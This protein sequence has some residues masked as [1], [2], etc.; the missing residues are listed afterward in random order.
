[1]ALDHDHFMGVALELSRQA[2]AEGNRPLGSLIVD[3][4]GEMWP[5][6]EYGLGIASSPLT[7]GGRYWGHGG[8]IHGYETRGGVTEN[9]RAFSVAVTALPG[10]FQ[11]TPE[12]A[13]KAHEAVLA[14]VDSALCGK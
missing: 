6:A 4:K 14:T 11:D 9:G 10:T 3:T 12:D 5:G 8:D 1:M 13:Q 2:A 7:C